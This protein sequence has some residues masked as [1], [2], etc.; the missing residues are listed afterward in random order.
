MQ[1]QQQPI[2]HTRPE[3]RTPLSNLNTSVGQPFELDCELIGDPKPNIFWKLNGKPLLISDR[4][5]VSEH[6]IYSNK[7]IKMPKSIAN[8]CGY[9]RTCTKISWVPSMYLCDMFIFISLCLVLKKKTQ[10][11][12]AK[13]MVASSPFSVWHTSIWPFTPMEYDARVFIEHKHTKKKN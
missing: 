3:F 5:K 2:H 6:K 9:E 12:T 10:I 8:V 11:I 4:V 7:L 13:I 1:S